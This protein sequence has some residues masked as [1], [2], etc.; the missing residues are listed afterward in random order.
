VDP[1]GPKTCGSGRIRNTDLNTI[2]YSP[3]LHLLL[4]VADV[5]VVLLPAVLGVLR[6]EVGKNLEGDLLQG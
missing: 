2:L 6:A 1:D 3:L 4:V 5:A